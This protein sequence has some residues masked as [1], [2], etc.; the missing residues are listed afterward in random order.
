L[1]PTTHNVGA[2][3]QVHPL[4]MSAQPSSHLT[5]RASRKIQTPSAS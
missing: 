2:P 1:R 3:V 4:A 5:A